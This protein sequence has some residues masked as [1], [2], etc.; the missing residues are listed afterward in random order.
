[1]EEHRQAERLQRQLQQEQAYLL[2]LQH[3]HRRPHAQQPQPP[4][5][6][7]DRSKPSYHAPEPKPHYDLADRTREVSAFPY[8]LHVGPEKARRSLMTVESYTVNARVNLGVSQVL[9]FVFYM[10]ALVNKC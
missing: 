7:Q 5:Q 8:C 10:D 1:M 2:S 3:D 9:T 6:Q 4:P